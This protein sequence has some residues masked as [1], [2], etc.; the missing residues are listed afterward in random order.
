MPGAWA[1]PWTRRW[2]TVVLQAQA[3]ITCHGAGA[4]IPITHTAAMAVLGPEPPHAL[5]DV[6]VACRLAL[7]QWRLPPW[8]LQLRAGY[9]RPADVRGGPGC[10]DGIPRLFRDVVAARDN[11]VQLSGV[12]A[13]VPVHDAQARRL[14]QLCVDLDATLI[15]GVARDELLRV[16]A[17]DITLTVLPGE[18]TPAAPDLQGV[19]GGSDAGHGHWLWYNWLAAEGRLPQV[20]LVL[21]TVAAVQGPAAVVQGALGTLDLAIAG[22]ACHACV[23]SLKAW[24]KDDVRS[25]PEAVVTLWQALR[26]AC[27]L[28]GYRPCAG[29]GHPCD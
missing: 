20:Q 14:V 26:Q 29:R 7:R 8:H 6:V 1:G 23:T 15:A 10:A 13:H 2:A 16:R 4:R 25:L 19:L 27:P 28:C 12:K 11:A 21:P 22:L 9:G 3:L 5:K 17:T 24:L 18:A